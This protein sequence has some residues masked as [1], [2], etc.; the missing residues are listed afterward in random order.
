MPR[1]GAVEDFRGGVH[2]TGA[3]RRELR[4]QGA[5][6]QMVARKR[7]GIGAGFKRE[8]HLISPSARLVANSGY[9][10]PSGS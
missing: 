8:I 1:G 9:L 5:G 3:A 4:P 6:G 2:V 7:V 10:T